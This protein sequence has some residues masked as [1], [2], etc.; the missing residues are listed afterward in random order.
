MT[1]G[2]WIPTVIF[3]HDFLS[4]C[5][6]RVFA[7]FR[8]VTAVTAPVTTWHGKKLNDFNDVTAVTAVTDCFWWD[9]KKARSGEPNHSKMTFSLEGTCT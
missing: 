3:I 8:T 5:T 2:C 9:G 1:V 7:L 6:T 4:D